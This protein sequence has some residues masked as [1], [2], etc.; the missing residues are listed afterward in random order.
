[1]DPNVS[2]MSIVCASQLSLGNV[3]DRRFRQA[4]KKTS[5]LQGRSRSL[6]AERRRRNSAFSEPT[7]ERDGLKFW[8]FSFS[9]INMWY[10]D[11]GEQVAE[12]A[13]HCSDFEASGDNSEVV[14]L[15]SGR[16]DSGEGVC[17]SLEASNT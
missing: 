7:R 6:D 13:T 4:Q 3:T 16:A 11:F 17:Q 14:D 2:I 10:F 1:M 8:N 5:G 15:D 9:T 12:T